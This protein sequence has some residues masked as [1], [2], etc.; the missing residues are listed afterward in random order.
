MFLNYNC[1]KC[2]LGPSER[3]EP[4]HIFLDQGIFYTSNYR[5]SRKY[6]TINMTLKML[7]NFIN[8]KNTFRFGH[9]SKP[10]KLILKIVIF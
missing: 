1:T 2:P 10:S 8:W 6:L 4:V 5:T 9:T 3:F 7:L